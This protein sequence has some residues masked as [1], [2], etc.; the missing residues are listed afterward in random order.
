M[1]FKS[2][3]KCFEL[4]SGLKIRVCTYDVTQKHMKMTN[5]AKLERSSQQA[6]KE[7]IYRKNGQGPK[8]LTFFLLVFLIFVI[9]LE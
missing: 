2:I 1:T 9:S 6:N 4:A 5:D 8:Y 7:A 3:L